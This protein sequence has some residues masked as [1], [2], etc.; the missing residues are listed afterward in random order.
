[1]FKLSTNEG[2]KAVWN[3]HFTNISIEIWVQSLNVYGFLGLSSYLRGVFVNY[4][5]VFNSGQGVVK[6]CTMLK[7]GRCAQIWSVLWL[8]PRLVVLQW[9]LCV[10]QWSLGSLTWFNMGHHV[11]LPKLHWS[12][13]KIHCRT[14]KWG[15]SNPLL[16]YSSQTQRWGDICLSLQETH[17][18]WKVLGFQLKSP[19]FSKKSHG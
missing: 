1:M 6:I 19:H 14:T 12:T 5:E 16:G 3:R 13:H 15:G 7:Y 4:T 18:H 2:V 17:T 8:P 11:K 9:I 10:D